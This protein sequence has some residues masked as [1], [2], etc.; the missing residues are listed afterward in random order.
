MGLPKGNKI[1]QHLLLADNQDTTE[2]DKDYA[3]YMGENK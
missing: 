1:I 3:E 2:K